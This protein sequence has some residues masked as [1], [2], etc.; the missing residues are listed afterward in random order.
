MIEKKGKL[1]CANPNCHFK[2]WTPVEEDYD[3]R[4]KVVYQMYQ[5]RPTSNHRLQFE[6]R[7]T[8]V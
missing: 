8:N 4:K 2:N 6:D 3:E 7:W 5:V 1:V